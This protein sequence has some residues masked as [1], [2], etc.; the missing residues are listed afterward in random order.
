[1]RALKMHGG[2][3]KGEL[4]VVDPEAVRR[5][6]PNLEKHLESIRCFGETPVVAINRF[7]SDAEEELAVVRE[8][9]TSLGVSVATSDHHARGGAGAEELAREVVRRAERAASPFRPLYDWSAPVE[10]KVRAVARAMYGAED[11]A[12]TKAARRDLREIE[13]LGFAGLPVCIAK[14]PGSLSDDARLRG[15]PRDFEITVREVQVN[16]GAGFLV[17]LTGD[18]L[19]MPGLPSNPLAESIDVR[20]GRIVGLS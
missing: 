5:G 15:R 9:C 2:R 6:L 11:V 17:V 8:S 3:R 1:M 4:D 10:E 19:R 7:A 20:D 18:I 13:R 16:A 14:I 12:Y